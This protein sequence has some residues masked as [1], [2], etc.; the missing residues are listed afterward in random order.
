MLKDGVRLFGT[1]GVRGVANV[2]LTPEFALSIGRAAGSL[3]SGGSVLVGRDTRR[4]GE[5]LS[6]ALQ[7]G[8]HSAGVDT[9]DVG[10]M[11][12]GGISLLTARS[13]AE[14][15]AV[16]S[17]SHNPAPDNG[18]K[19][20]GASGGK[21]KDS[22]EDRIEARLRS[23]GSR[24]VP[25]GANVGTR[26]WD[27]HA[28]DRYVGEMV[29][30]ASY[31]FNGID[32]LLDCANGAAYRA[33][34]T[35]FQRLKAN[36]DVAFAEPSGMNINEGCGATHPAALAAQVRGR[37]GFAFDG[38]ADRMIAVDEDGV[39]ANGDVVMA[40]IARHWKAIGKLSNDTVVATVMSNL[41]FR[42]ALT[43]AGITLVQT[44]VGD[45]YVME[46]MREHRAVLGGE[47]SGHVIFLDRAR[48]GDGLLSGI[49][50]LEVMAGTGRQLRDLRAEAMVEYPQVLLNIKVA[51]RD[52]LE[53]CAAVWAAVADTESALGDD[54]RVLV[55]ASGTEPLVRVM[56]EASSE[57]LAHRYADEI[58][59][60]VTAE[61]GEEE[62][63][64]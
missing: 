18:I 24:T 2:E 64:D 21:L 55:R 35:L 34:P 32:L 6:A 44:K 46:A 23:S 28:L 5:M 53:G 26:F 1:D 38:D 59:A 51:D 30:G 17:A 41:G 36:V 8:F 57:E 47:Q 22:E 27:D 11:P 25:F 13:E 37:V 39:I 33:A 58:A 15:G 61:L 48:T 14:M 7:A 4:S 45:R 3:L 20:L 19:L 10:V 56:V 43:E 40:I 60:V 29:A 54:G 31:S 49:R 42:K 52:G 63:N 50:L 9:I 62:S 16:V 12:S